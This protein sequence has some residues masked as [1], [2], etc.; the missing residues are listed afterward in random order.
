MTAENEDRNA[1][2]RPVFTHNYNTLNV[3]KKKKKKAKPLVQT[4]SL[5]NNLNRT[6]ITMGIFSTARKHKLHDNQS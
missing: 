3:K 6:K 1:W 2:K 4:V 5:L